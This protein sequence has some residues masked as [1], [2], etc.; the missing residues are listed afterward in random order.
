VQ[1]Q[2]ES[3]GAVGEGRTASVSD[4]CLAAYHPGCATSPSSQA[5]RGCCLRLRD[6][7]QAH[8][9]PDRQDP[10]PLY[11]GGRVRDPRACILHQEGSDEASGTRREPR[12]GATRIVYQ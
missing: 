6:V 9:Q 2:P 7:Q 8:R 1:V 4:R 11:A 3:P 5:R 12:T 10:Q